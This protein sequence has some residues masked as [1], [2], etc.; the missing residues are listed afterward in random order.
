[1]RWI[2]ISHLIWI[3][4]LPFC[5]HFFLPVCSNN[6][7]LILHVVASKNCWMRGKQCRPWSDST[8][9]G[10][11]SGSTLFAQFCQSKYLGFNVMVPP[12]NMSKNCRMNIKQSRP[13]LYTTLYWILRS[14]TVPHVALSK[15]CWKSSKQCRS[16]SDAT[17]CSIRSGSTLFAQA[18]LSQYLGLLWFS[19]T[20]QKC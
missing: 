15:N 11:W 17:F 14:I 16:W 12:F 8:V 19:H 1:M 13:W 18:Y 4:S 20:L 10:I 3:Y 7:S 5:L 9:C 6:Q 2:I